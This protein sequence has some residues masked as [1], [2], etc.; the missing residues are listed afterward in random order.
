MPH[1]TYGYM[2]RKT[3]LEKGSNLFK[4]FFTADG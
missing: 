2:G 3:I 4:D 1:A